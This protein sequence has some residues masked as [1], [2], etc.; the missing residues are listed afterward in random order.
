MDSLDPWPHTQQKR[1]EVLQAELGI[2]KQHLRE[3]RSDHAEKL[4]LAHR[5]HLKHITMKTSM[6]K[7]IMEEAMIT[8]MTTTVM[9]T[10]VMKVKKRKDSLS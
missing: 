5:K 8:V 3:I 1:I 2:A 7:M 6:E 9:T 10:T 4:L